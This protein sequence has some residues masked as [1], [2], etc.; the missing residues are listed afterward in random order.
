MRIDPD[1]QYSGDAR[2]LAYLD[3]ALHRVRNIAGVEAAGVTDALPLGKNRTWG[4]GAK[5][6]VYPPNQYPLA[7]VH[8]VT[9]GYFQAI[10]TPLKRGRDLTA[11]DGPDSPPVMLVNETLTRALWPSDNPI[12][13]FIVGPCAKEREVVGVVSDVRHRALEQDSGSE[14]YI[15]MRQCG[16][17]GWNLVVR[18]SLPVNTLAPA[19]ES[20]L[21]SIAPELPVGGM[22]P[23]MQQ[24]DQAVSARRFTGLLLTGFAGFALLL[25]S[26]G[27]YGL[28]SYSVT[29]RTQDIGIRM[30]LGATAL[31]VQVRIVSGTLV[32]ASLG[33]VA[34]LTMSWA[35]VRSASG[36][37]Y[38]IGAGDPVTFAAAAV[39]LMAIAVLAGYLPARRVS[40]IDPLI[41]LR[42]E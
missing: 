19:V 41:C 28:I 14:M 18:S 10:G 11:H 15:P 22:R 7:F 37:L 9:E 35:L 13:K 39:I 16:D 33:L 4:A 27:I 6:I 17:R 23:L 8:I 25:A 21:R 24:V 38:G 31:N 40:G 32:L 42:A 5:G 20:S 26:L 2:Q 34:G 36:L 12:G 3:D 29:C 1:S 30:A